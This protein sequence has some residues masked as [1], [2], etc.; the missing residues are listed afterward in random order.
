MFR[1][2]S[3]LH[4]GLS[5][6]NH[7]K[8]SKDTAQRTQMQAKEFFIQV[9]NWLVDKL[10][11]ELADFKMSSDSAPSLPVVT[12]TNGIPH[13]LARLNMQ[14]WFDTN[15]GLHVDLSLPKSHGKYLPSTSV[16][17]CLADF[18]SPVYS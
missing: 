3:N 9:S 8:L 11:V 15:Q 18:F 16:L 4:T 2:H 13:N 7:I 6:C 10:V 14:L 12:D 1:A 17:N 5:E